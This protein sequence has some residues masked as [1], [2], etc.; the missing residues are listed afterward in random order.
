MVIRLIRYRTLWII[1]RS[2]LAKEVF[3][4]GNLLFLCC[5]YRNG[6]TL[7]FSDTPWFQLE[8]WDWLT[9]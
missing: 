6:T 8:W 4:T 3:F 7:A 1:W 2:A 9:T 5:V